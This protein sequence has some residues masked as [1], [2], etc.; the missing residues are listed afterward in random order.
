VTR[1]YG[2]AGWV[3]FAEEAGLA[4]FELHLRIDDR[5]RITDLYVDGGNREITAPLLRRLPLG[6]YRAQAL[7]RPDLMIAMLDAPDPGVREL[8]RS[9]Y[10]DEP[11]RAHRR[12]TQRFRLSAPAGGLSTDFLRDVARAYTDAVAAGERPNIALSEQ[13][14]VPKRTVEGWVYLARKGG[15]LPATNRGEQR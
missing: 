2:R 8:V 9:A 1:V 13:S 3:R 5:G 6:R 15:L 12:A 11:A 14:G 10:P 7:T 4:G